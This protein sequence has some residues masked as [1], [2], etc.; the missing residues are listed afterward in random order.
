[1]RTI[2][3]WGRVSA[4]C[5]D[6]ARES[7]GKNIVKPYGARVEDGKRHVALQVWDFDGD[8]YDMTIFLV[9]EDLSSKIVSSRAVRSRYYAI[10]VR[11]L[12]ELLVAAGF[13]NVK[14]LDDVFYQPVIVGTKST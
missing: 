13:K 14:R 6:Y 12:C 5:A 7:R 3:G 9:Q 1:M 2:P 8:R 4:N 11:R 10:G